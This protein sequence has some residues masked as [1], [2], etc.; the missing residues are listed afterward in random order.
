MDGQARHSSH[1]QLPGLFYTTDC[2]PPGSSVHGILQASALEQVAISFSRASSWPRDQTHVSCIGR[3]IFYH[4]SHQGSWASVKPV[5][6]LRKPWWCTWSPCSHSTCIKAL[7]LLSTGDGCHIPLFL[8]SAVLTWKSYQTMGIQTWRSGRYLHDNE[9]S[10]HF[11]EN[12]WQCL[13]PV[14]KVKLASEK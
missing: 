8:W 7:W 9:V 11:V 2:S 14:I 1:H 5:P 6:Y 10:C 13:S 12:N 3:Q 4:L